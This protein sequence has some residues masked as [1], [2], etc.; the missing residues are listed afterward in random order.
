MKTEQDSTSPPPLFL[1]RATLRILL[2]ALCVLVVG[3]A[4]ARPA[5]PKAIAAVLAEL[6]TELEW[7][8]LTVDQAAENL[9]TPTEALR[10]VRDEVVVINY[11]GAYAGPE[12]VLRTRVAN[13]GD[14]SALLAALLEKMGVEAR[15]ARANWPKA[16]APHRGPGPRRPLPAVKKLAD[17]LGPAGAT[18]AAP[19][20]LSDKQLKE[21]RDEIAASAK[22]VEGFLAA[23]GRAGMLT[24]IPKAGDIEPTRTDID[25]VWVQAKLDGKTWTNMD[26]VF[27]TLPRPSR[28]FKPFT[29]KPVTVTIRLEA[30]RRGKDGVKG[31][32]QWSGPCRDI[33]GYDIVLSYVPAT[34]R[35]QAADHPEKV[36]RWRPVLSAGPLT[37]VGEGFGPSGG[38]A[39]PPA[40]QDSCDFLRLAIEFNDPGG[41]RPWSA[42]Y[43]RIVQYVGAGYDPHE[44]VAFHRIGLGVAFVPAPVAE[45]RMVDEVLDV[46]RLRQMAGDG[47]SAKPPVVRGYSTRTIR[48][49]NSLLF[50]KLLATPADL[51]LGWKGPAV[52]VETCQLRKVKDRLFFAAR[53]DTLHESFG[54]QANQTRRQRMLWG[55]AT[56]AV[57]ARLLKGTSVNQA[58]LAAAKSL[59]LID[60][61]GKPATGRIDAAAL[62]RS[63]LDEGGVV[64]ASADAPQSAWALRPTGDLLG[65]FADG[66]F[67]V[68]AKGAGYITP[69]QGGDAFAALASEA[70]ST[71]GYAP[72]MLI[73][74]L[75]AYFNE[76][77]K[78]YGGA[79]AVLINLARTM[80]TGDMRY[81]LDNR[82]AYFRNLDRHLTNTLTRGF[83]RG[84]AESVTGACIGRILGTSGSDRT[85]HNVIDGLVAANLSLSPA[86]LILPDLLERLM[87]AVTIPPR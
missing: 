21:L 36:G 82:A 56:C 6:R 24:G 77:A 85:I 42:S 18:N 69:S 19:V 79:T 64:L 44:L 37:V 54:P 43:G 39:K 53:L 86:L 72:G 47:G 61:S 49:L 23:K 33:L 45:S 17:L 35:I 20:P 40:G 80:E 32:L 3:Q 34:K 60:K 25:W 51:D 4:H 11:G 78:A 81:M 10:F 59:R 50:I 68:Q 41:L 28:Y 15:L 27:P 70:M 73:T 52:I 48:N 57:E 8:G 84:W 16:A 9:K 29:P 87:D 58:L 71:L 38:P 75:T 76:L 22:V 55:L 5:T 63:V 2:S 13:A 30:G 46:H 26:A 62:K 14:K 7:P 12:A 1:H 74:P 65:V 31:V 67:G 66:P 83:I